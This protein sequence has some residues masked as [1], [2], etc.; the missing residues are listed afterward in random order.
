MHTQPSMFHVLSP[1]QTNFI[2]SLW[3]RRTP[4]GSVIDRD[5]KIYHMTCSYNN[6]ATQSLGGPIQPFTVPPVTDITPGQFMFTFDVVDTSF[7]PIQSVFPMRV[8]ARDRINL[9]LQVQS[10]ASNLALFC[11]RCYA[12]PSSSPNSQPQYSFIQSE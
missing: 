6:H 9:R 11:M 12:T 2:N 8:N 4:P 5:V 10:T 3:W 7:N 1:L